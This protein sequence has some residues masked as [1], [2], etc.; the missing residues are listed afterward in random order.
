MVLPATHAKDVWERIPGTH[1]KSFLPG[2]LVRSAART[3]RIEDKTESER[4]TKTLQ[5]TFPFPTLGQRIEH[6]ARIF[7][8]RGFFFLAP[9]VSENPCKT[10]SAPRRSTFCPLLSIF[11]FSSSLSS[12]HRQGA[13]CFLKAWR[14]HMITVCP[15]VFRRFFHSQVF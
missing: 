2:P 8:P 4:S 12:C 7:F 1:R 15:H 10:L 3:P 13:A 11:F 14:S 5:F 9:P 6:R